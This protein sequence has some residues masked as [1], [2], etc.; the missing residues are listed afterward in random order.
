MGKRSPR[1]H[2][3]ELIEM[4]DGKGK[5]DEMFPKVRRGIENFLS[6]QEG[7]IPRNK[8][9]A[10]GSMMI[11]LAM[12]LTQDVFAKHR[13]HSN[14]GHYSHTSHESHVSHSS[15]VS[16]DGGTAPSHTSSPSTTPS[17][18]AVT[19]PTPTPE[20]ALPTI[21]PIQTPRP[22]NIP[23]TAPNIDTISGI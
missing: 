4:A 2:G 3:K 14:S 21:P 8:I 20:P 7:N 12:A 9:L 13:S 18:P 6:D 23:N 16:G 10:V 1:E 17:T 15:H 22:N 19:T 11:L 5:N